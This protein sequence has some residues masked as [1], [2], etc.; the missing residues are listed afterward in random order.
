[1]AVPREIVGEGYHVSTCWC[2]LL[3][4][5]S[6]SLPSYTPPFQRDYVS[7][8]FFDD[9]RTHSFLQARLI[10]VNKLRALPGLEASTSTFF[11]VSTLFKSQARLL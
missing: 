7:G 6:R 11:L 4:R 2:G 5:R 10:K 1:M 3:V 9:R 8:R